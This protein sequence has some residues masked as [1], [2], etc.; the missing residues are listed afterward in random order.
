MTVGQP[1]VQVS[2]PAG[3]VSC[4]GTPKWRTA[5]EIGVAMGSPLEST[6]I[7][8][9]L[10]VTGIEERSGGKKKVNLLISLPGND[11]LFE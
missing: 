5:E 3:Y 1:S 6:G 9:K 11:G 4:E 8:F 10:T 7:R 2:H